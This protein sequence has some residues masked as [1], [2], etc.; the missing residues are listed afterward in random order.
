[1]LF[2]LLNKENSKNVEEKTK[3]LFEKLKSEFKEE[4][5]KLEEVHILPY[6]TIET[7]YYYDT[8]TLKVKIGREKMYSLIGKY[9]AFKNAFKNEECFSFGA[10]F[11]YYPEKHFFSEESLKLFQVINNFLARR[12]SNG[13]SII[14]DDDSLKEIMRIYKN[15]GIYIDDNKYIT[16]IKRAFPIKMDLLKENHKYKIV[17]NGAI[18]NIFPLTNNLE[19]ILLND[20]IYELDKKQRFLLEEC[21]KNN[22]IPFII[23][24]K[25][26]LFYYRGLNQYQSNKEKGYLIDTCLNAQDQYINSIEYFLKA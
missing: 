14:L 19:Y 4:P 2:R 7:S 11:T 9:N 10:N 1:M 21:L 23:L 22:I 12:Y 16:E 13:N 6:I 8:V 3:R 5:K 24:D 18:N 17:L 20:T 25:D 26:K 15:K